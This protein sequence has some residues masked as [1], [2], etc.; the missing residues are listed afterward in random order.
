MGSE[1][2]QKMRF[3]N[4]EHGYLT[5]IPRKVQSLWSIRYG[6]ERDLKNR[7]FLLQVKRALAMLHALRA[8]GLVHEPRRTVTI[9]TL[10]A[11][12]LR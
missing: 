11:Y 6:Y 4:K 5:D 3:V 2:Y 1:M 9:R 8:H 10:G 7:H 12:F